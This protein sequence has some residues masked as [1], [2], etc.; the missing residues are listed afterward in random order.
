MA[1]V[2][3]CTECRGAS[4]VGPEALGLMV[5]CPRCREPFLALEEATPVAK[6]P[7]RVEPVRARR[8][9]PSRPLAETMH[10]RSRNSP[11]RAPLRRRAAS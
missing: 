3:R 2:V 11:S 10:F 7:R 4:Q 8:L 1:V 6:P 5:V 9:R